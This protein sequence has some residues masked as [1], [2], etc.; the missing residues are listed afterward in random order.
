MEVD[1]LWLE[2][3]D[4]VQN[5]EWPDRED[6]TLQGWRPSQLC[7]TSSGDLLVTMYSDDIDQTQSK[8]VRY[9]SSTV[10]QTIQFDDK[11]QPLYSGNGII[12]HISEN[13]NLGI[14]VA[15]LRAGAVVVDNQT[16]KLRLKYRI[17]QE[18]TIWT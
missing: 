15:D 7:I 9:S 16:G 11:G 14:C 6:H 1:L 2:N 10:K 4:K 3:K 18:Q 17:Y 5:K 8:V 13:R 12:K